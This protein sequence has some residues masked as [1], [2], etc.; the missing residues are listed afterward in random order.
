MTVPY[1]WCL[2]VVTPFKHHSNNVFQIYKLLFIIAV[3]NLRTQTE[4][5]KYIDGIHLVFYPVSSKI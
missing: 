5:S 3:S 2:F 4:I 1:S